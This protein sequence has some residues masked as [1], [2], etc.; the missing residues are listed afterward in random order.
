MCGHEFMDTEC[1]KKYDC[2]MKC[3]CRIIAGINKDYE[4]AK[5]KEIQNGEKERNK[6]ALVG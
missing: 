4:K 2:E 3:M 5:R 6:L 1:F